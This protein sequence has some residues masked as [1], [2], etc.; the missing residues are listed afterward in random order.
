MGGEA[1]S[2]ASDS[3]S[4][5]RRGSRAELQRTPRCVPSTHLYPAAP[6][7]R[8]CAALVSYGRRALPLCTRWR[9]LALSGAARPLRSA[10][11]LAS[12]ACGGTV[13]S[14]ECQQ[15]PLCAWWRR[16]VLCWARGCCVRAWGCLAEVSLRACWAL[17]SERA[18]R[19]LSR[20]TRMPGSAGECTCFMGVCALARIVGLLVGLPSCAA[21]LCPPI[22]S[23][24]SHLQH[25][26]GVC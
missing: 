11:A 18:A 2:P 6:A 5:R 8:P 3:E 25:P 23:P 4:P 21:F 12:Q 17:R 16:A 9:H 1:E 13:T 7:H 10:W 14:L 26:H 19:R 22:F 24:P 20:K 15:M